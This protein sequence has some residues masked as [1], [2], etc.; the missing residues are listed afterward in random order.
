MV[1]VRIM[2]SYFDINQFS[3]T[4][5]LVF[6]AKYEILM[7]NAKTQYVNRQIRQESAFLLRNHQVG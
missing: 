2:Y 4:T 7:K 5:F 3:F 6:S 1:M